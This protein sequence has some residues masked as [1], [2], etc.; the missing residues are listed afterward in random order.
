VNRVEFQG[1]PSMIAALL[2]KREALPAPRPPKMARGRFAIRWSAPDVRRHGGHIA[3]RG[4]RS[5]ST[6]AAPDSRPACPPRGG[7]SGHADR[8]GPIARRASPLGLSNRWLP[9]SEAAAQPAASRMH[10]EAPGGEP[11][12]G[13][14]HA[15]AP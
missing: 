3:H 9:E 8:A 11:R 14:P 13:R 6:P 4:Q 12:P 2:P 7:R 5:Q 1:L 15:G 10:P